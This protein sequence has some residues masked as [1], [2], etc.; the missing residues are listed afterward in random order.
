MAA[1]WLEAAVVRWSD[2][3]TKMETRRHSCLSGDNGG[4][5]LIVFG[6]YLGWLPDWLEQAYIGQVFLEVIDQADK[7]RRQVLRP[8][9]GI[10]DID[11]LEAIQRRCCSDDAG[12]R[13]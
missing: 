9:V 12:V 2:R 7:K 5:A 3:Y 6:T 8:A 4:L 11:G 1:V 10:R 13:G